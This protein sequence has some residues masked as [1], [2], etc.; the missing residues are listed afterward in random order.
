MQTGEPY[1]AVF[2]DGI[3]PTKAFSPATTGTIGFIPSPNVGDNV[4]AS[5]AIS[6]HSRDT[7]L[8]QRVD[9]LNKMTGNWSGYYYID[10]FNS[11]NPYGSSSF[12]TGFGSEARNRNQLATLTNTYIISPSAVN[13]FRLSYTRIVVR[14]VP[15][16]GNAPSLESM[17]FVTGEGTLGINNAGPTG[18]SAVPYIGLNNF[19]F[20]DPGTGNAIQ[21]TY[22]IGN[23]FSKILGRHTLKFGWRIPLLP[24]EQS[25]RRR[26]RSDSSVSAEEK[27]ATMWR[28]TCLAHRHHIPSPACRLSMAGAGTAGPS[29]RIRSKSLRT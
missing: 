14:S 19:G 9:F 6:T 2:P 23:N 15:Q 18:Y 7:K 29:H 5:S 12:P 17:G 28:I 10:D 1:S 8:G 26:L 25:Q 16:G 13:E 27:P 21:N 22:A 4:Y 20:G 11:L 24:D 3:I